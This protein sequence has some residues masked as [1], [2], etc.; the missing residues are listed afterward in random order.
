MGNQKPEMAVGR[1]VGFSIKF[2]DGKSKARDGS[3]KN[4]GFLP[5][6]F[7]LGNQKPEMAVGRTRGFSLKI[8]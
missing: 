6:N 2:F 4:C 8:C 7:L 1:T 3:W 5:R